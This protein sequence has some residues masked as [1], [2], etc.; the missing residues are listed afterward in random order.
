MFWLFFLEFVRKC[1]H[2]NEFLH[3]RVFIHNKWLIW[4][5]LSQFSVSLQ[6]NAC[7]HV[8]LGPIWII[9]IC[10]EWI[11][12]SNIAVTFV[13]SVNIISN[14]GVDDLPKD[15][16]TVNSVSFT[17]NRNNWRHV[18]V[19]GTRRLFLLWQKISI[20]LY[21]LQW[22]SCCLTGFTCINLVSF[23]NS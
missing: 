18:F 17:L 5:L 1:D 19:C 6:W 8:Y 12:R 4:L 2:Q 14:A 3:E 10:Y 11:A 20:W 23:A 22:I 13:L 7:F 16:L 15:W 9:I 21:F